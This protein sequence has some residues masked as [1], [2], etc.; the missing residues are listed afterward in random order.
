M[1]LAGA[2]SVKR[3][4]ILLALPALLVAPI[5]PRPSAASPGSPGV[6]AGS[7]PP[8]AREFAQ[9]VRPLLHPPPEAVAA[10]AAAL[11]GSLASASAR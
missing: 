9:E 5:L 7:A 1:L 6:G 10:S 8:L 4:A 11:A 2:V 3:R